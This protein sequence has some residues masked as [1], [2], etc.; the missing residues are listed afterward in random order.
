METDGVTFYTDSK[1]DLGYIQNESRS[2][3]VYVANR[4]KLIRKISSPD[5]WSYVDTSEKPA[6]LATCRSSAQN[7]AASDWLTGSKFLK[8]TSSPRKEKQEKVPL[9]ESDPEVCKE[10]LT[11]VTQSSK[12]CGL[13][14]ERFS[15][16]S[17]LHSL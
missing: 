11:S 6:D 5:Q 15:R 12:R 7:L 1:V 17:R 9:N 10:V 3:Y 4:F 8:A 16:F 13:G 2:F 14:A